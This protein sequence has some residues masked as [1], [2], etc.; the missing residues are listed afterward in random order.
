MYLS[1][2]MVT[3]VAGRHLKNAV[4]AVHVLR[5]T[6]GALVL[7]VG[8]GYPRRDSFKRALW[9]DSLGD[10]PSAVAVPILAI[11]ALS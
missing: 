10:P 7:G 1:R 3:G 4:A 9:K 6:G 5:C 2:S 8:C 11:T